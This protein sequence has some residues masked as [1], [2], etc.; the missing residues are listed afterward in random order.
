[1][2]NFVTS[3]LKCHQFCPKKHREVI[4]GYLFSLMLAAPKH[5]LT[6]AGEI[7]EY[8]KS[9]Y[10][11]L[12]SE[13]EDAVIA[14]ESLA[15]YSKYVTNRNA[16]DRQVLIDGTKYTIAIIIDSTLHRR[17]TLHTD[18]SQQH[19]HGDGFVVGHQWTNIVLVIN[20]NTIPLPPIPFLTKKK[21][22]ERG[23]KYLTE[24]QKIIAYINNLDLK[25]WVGEHS[26]DEVLFL[27]DGGYDNKEI[28]QTI[29]N[30]KWTLLAAIKKSRG[31]RTITGEKCKQVHQLFKDMRGKAE[32]KS[33]HINVNKKQR[34]FRIRR[35]E[36]TLNGVKDVPVIIIC[37]EQSRKKKRKYLVS[38]NMRLS[39]RQIVLAYML[40]WNI[41][42]FHKDVKSNLGMEEFGSQSFESIESHV[43]Y[44]YLAYLLL[45]EMPVNKKMGIKERQQKL[46][47]D[48]E[49]QIRVIE[50]KKIIQTGCQFNGVNR[51]INQCKELMAA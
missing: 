14:K 8:D 45:K 48:S 38:S 4:M 21:C 24:P 23:I 9:T 27:L 44:V 43:N 1:M 19:N 39:E 50:L 42:L 6:R 10:S 47:E 37:S 11:R 13:S 5:T 16:N 29:A 30:K 31:V 33:I 41:E 49:K 51:I 17:H 2:N 12:L 32:W 22:K 28:Q 26:V 46:K 40:R 18:N 25:H 15:Y 3:I 36:G 20:N 7:T 35:T 34:R